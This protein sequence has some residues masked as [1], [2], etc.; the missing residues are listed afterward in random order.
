MAEKSLVNDDAE[1]LGT[2]DDDELLALELELLVVLDDELPQADSAMTAA[3]ASA[4]KT[5]L[6]L[7]KCTVTPPSLQYSNTAAG[8]VEA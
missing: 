2:D 3:I 4:A 1:T 6:L 8:H 5:I 7:S